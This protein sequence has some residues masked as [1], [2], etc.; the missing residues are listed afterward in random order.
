MRQIESTRHAIRAATRRRRRLREE[1]DDASIRLPK[2]RP[3][4]AAI[5]E[6]LDYARFPPVHER[7]LPTY[8]AIVVDESVRPA[9]LGGVTD[10]IVSN[11]PSVLRRL[12]DGRH[13]FILRHGN[14]TEL[15][16]FDVAHDRE[17]A[18]VHLRAAGRGESTVVMQRSVNGLVR[19][20]A[21]D[22]LCV[23]DGA[24]WWTKPYAASFA[25]AVL[26]EVPA[27]S[28]ETL[29]T[30]LDFCV[31]TMSP[32]DAGTTLLWALQ[33]D[34]VSEVEGLSASRQATPVPRLPFRDIATRAAIRQLLSQVDGA[35]ILNRDGLVIAI[36]A[37]L[38]S[39][40]RSHNTL[41]LDPARGTRHASAR[42]Y[43]FDHQDV[44]VFVVS[45]DGPVTVFAAGREITSIASQLDES[46]DEPVGT[47]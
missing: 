18:L 6:E 44:I 41:R 34:K 42:R 12:A 14:Q 25:Q 21:P 47:S 19:V 35:A 9:D 8:G 11:D 27:A 1:L 13:S 2:G 26:D 30:I 46:D 5:V 22:A 29:H 20:L 38:R 36:E 24:H 32:A 39:S 15:L 33:A 37:Q 7:L 10:A 16:L 31:H 17:A 28:P 4:A 43:S 23:W 40:A 45:R 3:L